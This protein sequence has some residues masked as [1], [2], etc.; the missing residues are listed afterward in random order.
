MVVTAIA[1]AIRWSPSPQC[2]GLSILAPPAC[3]LLAIYTFAAVYLPD[4]QHSVAMFIYLAA[5][6]GFALH[7]FRFKARFHWIHGSVCSLLSGGA[8]VL[9]CS[10]LAMRGALTDVAALSLIGS[11]ESLFIVCWSAGLYAFVARHRRSE[12]RS[13]AST[14]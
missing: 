10:L 2:E 8:V 13:D 4:A 14:E 1:F 11:C 12:S 6:F 9:F 3:L 7:N 5:A